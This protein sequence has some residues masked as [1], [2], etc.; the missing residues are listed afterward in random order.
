MKKSVGENL[1]LL[2]F[3]LIGTAIFYGSWTMKIYG[4]ET[5]NGQHYGCLISGLLL[6]TILWQIMSSFLKKD[7][8]EGDKKV[9]FSNPV[10]L[11]I[12]FIVSLV[13]CFGIT[14]VGYFSSTFAFS[15]VMMLVLT[16]K[17]SAKSAGIYAAGSLLFCVAL[18]FLFQ[19]MQVYM[20][21]TPLI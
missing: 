7:K 11:I 21:K 4:N 20:P 6:V 3:F 2:F 8:E 18:Y 15:L 5:F 17:R 16:D 19:F 9:T 1:F 13:Y 10:G 12:T 14:K